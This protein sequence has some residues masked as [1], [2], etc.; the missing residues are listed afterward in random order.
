VAR[1]RRTGACN[2]AS[3]F[4][5]FDGFT[6]GKD[7]HCSPRSVPVVLKKLQAFQPQAGPGTWGGPSWNIRRCE[8]RISRAEALPEDPNRSAIKR[9]GVMQER[10]YTSWAEADRKVRENQ[11]VAGE[12]VGPCI[13][14]AL[15]IPPSPSRRVSSRFLRLPFPSGN[16]NDWRTL[17]GTQ[18]SQ[19]ATDASTNS[20]RA[21]AISGIYWGGSL[22]CA[23]P[24]D[25]SRSCCLVV[26]ENHY[27][28][29]L[30]QH[31]PRARAAEHAHPFSHRVTAGVLSLTFRR[32]VNTARD[33]IV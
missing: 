22:P 16:K 7:T 32:S 23:M 25:S 27:R 31:H 5:P 30:S 3:Q 19:R 15:E 6:R 11:P 26:V 1:L 4:E 18:R 24:V 33:P 12:R 28:Y 8:S 10:T 9:V 29:L 2:F 14:Q 17:R 21:I 20:D 13:R